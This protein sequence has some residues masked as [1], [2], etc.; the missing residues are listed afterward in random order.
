MQHHILRIPLDHPPQPPAR[1]P[2]TILTTPLGAAAAA[3]LGTALGTPDALP[4]AVVPR[5]NKPAAIRARQHGHRAILAVVAAV[6]PGHGAVVLD[7]AVV[8][9]AEQHR[10]HREAEVADL[11]PPELQ[12]F[13]VVHDEELVGVVVLFVEVPL[14]PAAYAAAGGSGLG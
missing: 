5:K 9:G 14:A 2:S 10:Q 8:V 11:A 12:V 1:T 3:P 4:P 7:A 13:F 6:E